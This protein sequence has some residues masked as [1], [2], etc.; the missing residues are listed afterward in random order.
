MFPFSRWRITHTYTLPGL[1]VLIFC[2][3]YQNIQFGFL[4]AGESILLKTSAKGLTCVECFQLLRSLLECDLSLVRSGRS[5]ATAY[6]KIPPFLPLQTA[7]HAHSHLRWML[8][9]SGD[10]AAGRSH[11]SSPT[12]TSELTLLQEMRHTSIWEKLF[13]LLWDSFYFRN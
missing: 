4:A 5:F 7:C 12:F 1:Q 11:Q 6:F 9:K 10:R 2:D 13:S 8:T 3:I